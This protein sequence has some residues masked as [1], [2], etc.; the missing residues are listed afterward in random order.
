[1]D[2][3]E[4]VASRDPVTEI[5]VQESSS[6]CT[7]F[8]NNYKKV[9]FYNNFASEASCELHVFLKKACARLGVPWLKHALN[10]ACAR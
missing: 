1:M 10:N 3:M 5:G 8:E 7:V 2:I 9:S 4:V 6:A